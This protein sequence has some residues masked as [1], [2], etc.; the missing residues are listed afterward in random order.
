ME[1][2]KEKITGKTVFVTGATGLI[3]TSLCRK[4]IKMGAKVVALVRDARKAAARLPDEVKLVVGDATRVIEYAGDV[5]FIVHAASPTASKDFCDHPV[6]VMEAISKG[7]FN[8]LSFAMAK[9]ISGLV[10]LSTKIL[11]SS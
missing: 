9:K 2:I 7:A 4:L 10:F 6:E 11:L 8:V 3:G 1:K 5:D